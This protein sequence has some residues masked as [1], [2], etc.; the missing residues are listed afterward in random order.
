MRTKP[1]PD[2]DGQEIRGNQSLLL[3]DLRAADSLTSC[4]GAV[5]WADVVVLLVCILHVYVDG[6]EE[7][8]NPPASMGPQS[9]FPHPPNAVY[10]V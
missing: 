1:W 9:G 8:K 2:S 10:P 3:H 5:A 7:G 4:E 6:E